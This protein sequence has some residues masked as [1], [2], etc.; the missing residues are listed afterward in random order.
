MLRPTSLILTAA[1]AAGAHQAPPGGPCD[2][3]RP[4]PP[5]MSGPGMGEPMRRPEPGPS[6]LRFLDLTAP[7]KQ[8]VKAI[9]DKR[10]PASTALHRTMVAKAMALRDGHEDPALA[11]PQLRA[12]QAAESE[13]RL[14][15][16]LDERAEFLE[17]HALLTPD[18]QAKAGR[19]RRARRQE[20]E[21]RQAIMAETG[22]E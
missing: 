2:G 12:L 7:Q 18:Q 8:A 10:R 20:R 11:E 4:G 1:L 9:L 3:G 16:L 13:A 22:P 21:A 17:I 14:Q 19:L 15:L 5:P 6:M